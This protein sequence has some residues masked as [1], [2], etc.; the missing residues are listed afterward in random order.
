[1]KSVRTIDQPHPWV[2]SPTNSSSEES[3][4]IRCGPSLDGS[5][6]VRE[7]IE[8]TVAQCSSRFAL[9][10]VIQRRSLIFPVEHHHP[11]SDQG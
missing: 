1:M 10:R 7:A 3:R 9:R 4:Q 2:L 5:K 8:A 6:S 11:S